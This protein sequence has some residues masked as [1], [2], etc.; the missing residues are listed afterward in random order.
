ML[1]PTIGHRR[2]S[3]TTHDIDELVE[4]R[5]RQRTFDG[6]LVF[7]VSY[8]ATYRTITDTV[9]RP[10]AYIRTALGNFG[11]A[12]LILKVFNKEFARSELLLLIRSDLFCALNERASDHDLTL[13]A[14]TRLARFPSPKLAC[15]M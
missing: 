1:H 14:Q 3:W 6:K 9:A 4:L 13:L 10:G 15:S 11:Y 2:D 5:A 12:L 8:S 7:L